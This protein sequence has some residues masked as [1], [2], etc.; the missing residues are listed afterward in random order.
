M[1]ELIKTL[2]EEELTRIHEEDDKRDKA[3]SENFAVT[4]QNYLQ[5]NGYQPSEEHLLDFIKIAAPKVNIIC[6]ATMS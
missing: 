1:D 5:S 6:Y 2:T 4:Y 3:F